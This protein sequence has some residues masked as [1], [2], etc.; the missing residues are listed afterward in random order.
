MARWNVVVSEDTD[1][2]VRSYLAR[3]GGRKCDL[4]HF[5]G[6]AV[7]QAISWETVE[8]IQERNRRL[9]AEEAQAIADE[10]VAETGADRS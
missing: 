4:S 10:A 6:R 9:S 8:A 2:T 3:I 5:V 7:R 1:R